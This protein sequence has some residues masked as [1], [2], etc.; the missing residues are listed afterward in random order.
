MSADLER[1]RALLAEA[2]S[3]APEAVAEDAGPETL[4][5][6]DSLAQMRL[7]LA[8]EAARGHTVT[9]EEAVEIFSLPA[10]AAALAAGRN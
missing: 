6:W 10:I 9:M 1:A 2:L 4:E 3:I 8:I 5:A 7:I